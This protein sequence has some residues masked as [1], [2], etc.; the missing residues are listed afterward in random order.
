M[1]VQNTTIQRKLAFFHSLSKTMVEGSQN[2]FESKYKSSHNVKIGEIWSDDVGYAIDF[3]AALNE[4]NNNS[5]VTYREKVTLSP[6]PFSNN[7]AY[8]LLDGSEFVR[9]WISPTDIPDPTT[10]E[11]SLGYTLR[12]YD[13]D[14]NLISGTL[15]NWEVNYYAGIIHFQ[16]GSTPTDMGWGDIKA[17]FFEYTGDFGVTG[18][19]SAGITGGTNGLSVSGQT[20]GLGGTLTNNTSILGNSNDFQISG[21]NLFE[22]GV[23]D[24]HYVYF[25]GDGGLQYSG[26]TFNFENN[27]LIT[28][29][30]VDDKSNVVNV[31]GITGTSQLYNATETDDFIG[32]VAGTVI[33]LPTTPKLGQRI[34]VADIDGNAYNDN[35]IVNGN[36]NNILDDNQ[37]KINTDYGSLTFIYNTQGFWSVVGFTN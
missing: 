5:A 16:P 22:I 30:Y 31:T 25:D 15:G 8:Y 6:I 20:V 21:V 14:D 13:E 36:G 37:A 27:S 3:T 26:D 2:V 7:Q 32:V 23:D 28:K 10:N 34:I 9:P 33:N 12:L 18:I 4:S 11:P 1:S 17:S 24:G 35:I 29:E 19:T